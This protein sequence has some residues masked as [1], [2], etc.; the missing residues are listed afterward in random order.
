[1]SPL[2]G[3]PTNI[4]RAQSRDDCK[5]ILRSKRRLSQD[6]A[7]RRQILLLPALQDEV[8]LSDL[9]TANWQSAQ[10]RLV[11]GVRVC[12]GGCLHERLS[13]LDHASRVPRYLRG[14]VCGSYWSAG[15]GRGGSGC[16]RSGGGDGC[17]VRSGGGFVCCDL[18][19]G[20]RLIA[21]LSW[22][23][24]GMEHLEISVPDFDRSGNMRPERRRIVL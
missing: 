17:A 4:F 8:F 9:A 18:D 5:T 20:G 14:G 19:A 24:H 22:K 7:L 2:K 21:L 16:G 23:L 12:L 11:S 13:L 15:A 10:A 6:L 3:R 1:M